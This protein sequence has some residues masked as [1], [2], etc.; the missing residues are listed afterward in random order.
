MSITTEMS[1]LG[2][3]GQPFNTTNAWGFGGS[4][5]N[6][7]ELPDGSILSQGRQYY[8]HANPTRYTYLRLADETELSGKALLAHLEALPTPPRIIEQRLLREVER[9][10]TP[11]RE[12]YSQGSLF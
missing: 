1:R 11:P 8:R 4:I 6:R 10:I 12:S 9:L 2:I 5:G 3:K 7:Y